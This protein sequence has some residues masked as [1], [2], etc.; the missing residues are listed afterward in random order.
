MD[1]EIVR[2]VIYRK[3]C[4]TSRY[5]QNGCLRR[6][7]HGPINRHQPIF[8]NSSIKPCMASTPQQCRRRTTDNSECETRTQAKDKAKTCTNSNVLIEN[9][10]PLKRQKTKHNFNFIKG[11][12]SLDGRPD[13]HTNVCRNICGESFSVTT[14]K[15]PTQNQ[16][17]S[18]DESML[19]RVDLDSAVKDYCDSQNRNINLDI[20]STEH[21]DHYHVP[22]PSEEHFNVINDEIMKSS[23]QG[24]D[25][26]S[27]KVRTQY[28]ESRCDK[29]RP[30]NR[31][32]HK[33]MVTNSSYCMAPHVGINSA[34]NEHFQITDSAWVNDSFS[35][36]VINNMDKDIP[37]S[38]C[39]PLSNMPLGEK[40]KRALIS[41]VQKPV[42]PKPKNVQVNAGDEPQNSSSNTEK[43]STFFDIGPFFGLP[44]KVKSL[45]Q[46]FK[47]I[48]DLYPWQK[49]CLNLVALQQRKN[50]VYALPTSG[51]KTLVAEMLILRE[52][53]CSRKNAIFVVPYV[54]IVQEKVRSLAPF[55]LELDF[56]VEEYA[57][58][59]GQY[60]PP[61]RRRKQT[62]YVATIEKA[63]GLT[64]SLIEAQRMK[65]VGLCIVDELHLVGDSNGRGSVLE[66][67][68]TKLLYL[69]ASIQIVG[70][71]ATI[72]NLHEIATF[73]DAEMFTQDFRPVE[74]KEYVKCEN[75]LYAVNLRA[76]CPDEFLMLERKLS[77]SYSAA[78]AS[79]DPDMI[80]GLVGEVI[81]KSSCLVFC[82]TKKSCEN[83][84]QLICSVLPK[85]ILQYKK[86]EK[87]ALYR[88][89]TSEGNGSVCP[90]LRKILPF[91]IAYHH[92]GLTADE[93]NL[94]QE[95]YQSG[96]LCCICCTSTLAAGVN[97]PAKRVILRSPYIGR[98]FIN[99]SRYKQMI[100]RAGRVGF[101]EMGESILI[102]K[103]NETQKVKELLSS[104]MDEVTSSLHLNDG[105]G[106]QNLVLSA[107]G[108]AQIQVSCLTIRV[109]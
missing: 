86:E 39:S 5:K 28:S 25:D 103:T 61:K 43:L 82:P 107:V 99:L 6:H 85:E 45:I 97:L 96:T 52:L 36:D 54:A 78:A 80:G 3:S 22:N 64:N 73:L 102:C 15:S 88:A 59:K 93:K 41:N 62:V 16:M 18:L 90:V 2:K 23:S 77:F 7:S 53:F 17:L 108:L 14:V 32:Q 94:L 83:V 26:S 24:S 29:Y 95:A 81:P 35:E 101:G 74:L 106:I 11:I 10:T 12:T 70:M 84:A 19:A 48:S 34:Q 13:K 21:E 49:E 50:L 33:D 9:V 1:E 76:A 89:L 100:G 4:L 55:G 51:G 72:G 87:K 109:T 67:L 58:G 69:Q 44:L 65:E 42:T 37:I 27:C 98:D 75:K 71:S 47:G 68:L 56:F 63:L 38:N 31:I 60:P 105:L 92:S 46:K 79:I 57:A 104:P 40:I 20:Q 8:K 30:L 66:G 91:G